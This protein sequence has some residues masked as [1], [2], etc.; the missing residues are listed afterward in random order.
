MNAVFALLAALAPAADP[1]AADFGW[2]YQSGFVIDRELRGPLRP[3]V[4][5]AGD[6]ILESDD[7]LTWTIGH[8]LAKSGYPHHSKIV[9]QRPDGTLAILQAG[10]E[11]GAQSKINIR[12]EL[13]NLLQEEAKTG[14]K[15]KRIWIRPRKIPLTPEQSTALTK[16]AL[17]VEDRRMA[18]VRLGLLMTPVRA[19]GPL[20]TAVVGK[21]DYDR[22]GYFCSE[23]VATALAAAGVLDEELVRPSAMLPHDLFMGKSL[24]PWVNRGLKPMNDEWDP[25]ARWTSK[26][27]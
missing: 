14:R 22:R 10:A 8:Y 11:H 2:L 6:I 27:E 5:Q 19:K 1:L 21:V 26:S 23:L 24:N 9:F 3:Y 15:E 17:E 25:P 16:F 18:R 4:P 7:R 12:D 13:Q 20:R